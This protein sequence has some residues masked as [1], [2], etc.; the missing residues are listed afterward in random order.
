MIMTYK[1]WDIRIAKQILIP[2]NKQFYAIAKKR[3]KHKKNI[4]D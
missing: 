2:P 1:N 3:A 4:P